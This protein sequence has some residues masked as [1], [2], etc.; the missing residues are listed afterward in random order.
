MQ[1]YPGGELR[2]T[3]AEAGHRDREVASAFNGVGYSSLSA[4][5]WKCWDE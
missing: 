5:Q 2:E 1:L 4:E 3:L